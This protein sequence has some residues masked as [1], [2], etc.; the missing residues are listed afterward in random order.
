MAQ[1]LAAP[2]VRPGMNTHEAGVMAAYLEVLAGVCFAQAA[3]V[4][5]LLD[6]SAAALHAFVDH[7]LSLA[8]YRWGAAGAC[9]PS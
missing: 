5:G 2:G 1:S 4:P 9:E 6:N 7:W 8:A 3:S